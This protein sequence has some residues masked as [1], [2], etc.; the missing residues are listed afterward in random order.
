MYQDILV[1]NMR[2]T[3]DRFGVLSVYQTDFAD[4]I[5]AGNIRRLNLDRSWG[6]NLVAGDSGNPAFV[7]VNGQLVLVSTNTFGGTG[8]KGPFFGGPNVQGFI[9]S[10]IEDLERQ[11]R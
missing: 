5:R 1:T 7:V 11:F 4:M 3:V 8:S 10:A 9:K 6:G 2:R